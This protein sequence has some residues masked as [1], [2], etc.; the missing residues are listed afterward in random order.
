MEIAS[1]TSSN[2]SL[3]IFYYERLY[4]VQERMSKDGEWKTLE[5]HDSEQRARDFVAG[6]ISVFLKWTQLMSTDFLS[7]EDCNAKIVRY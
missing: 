4:L 1:F 2:V 6:A 5:R 7:C 3:R